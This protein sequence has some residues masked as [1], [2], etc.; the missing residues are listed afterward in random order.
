[1]IVSIASGKGGTGKTSIALML[2]AAHNATLVDC[3]VEAPNCHLFLSTQSQSHSQ[4]VKITV[5]QVESSLCNGCG[6]CSDACRFNAIAIAGGKALV[7][8]ELC[9]SCEGCIL[10]C[11]DGAILKNT[12]TIGTIT[13]SFTSDIPGGHFVYGALAVGVPSAV[14]LIKAIKNELQQISSDIILDCPP[15]TS[16]SMVN[17]IADTDY[18]ILVTEP[19]PF[20]K[21]DLELAINVARF[22]KIPCGVV[23]NKSNGG[24]DDEIIE[25]FCN[26]K[27]ISILA[28]IPHSLSFAQAYSD[29]RIPT[30]FRDIAINISRQVIEKRGLMQ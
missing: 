28:K 18:C 21:H 25:K 8:D 2:A 30:L 22:L 26:E 7:F 15:G 14:P 20:G 5:P 3:D 4:D 13:H 11:N 12:K 1:M 10:A 9:H 16:C 29:G 17:A 24:S 19:T 23:I 27:R 6:L